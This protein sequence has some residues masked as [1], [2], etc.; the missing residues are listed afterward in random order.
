[1]GHSLTTASLIRG[2]LIANCLFLTSSLSANSTL[3]ERSPFLPPQANRPAN[4]STPPPA[5]PQSQLQFKGYFELNDELHFNLFDQRENKGSWVKLNVAFAGAK[6]VAFDRESRAIDVEING[7]ISRFEIIDGSDIPFAI[8]GGTD[9][10]SQGATPG[11]PAL[12]PPTIADRR[13][14]VRRRIVPPRRSVANTQNAAA[15]TNAASGYQTNMQSNANRSPNTQAENTEDA[16][17]VNPRLR[18]V[19]EQGR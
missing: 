16:P 12:N 19:V 3:L 11:S 14:V 10:A 4:T 2:V 7:E 1:M 9:V 5:A 6:V 13:S 18:H 15:R 17:F 8:S